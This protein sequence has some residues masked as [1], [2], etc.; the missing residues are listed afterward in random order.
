MAGKMCR[1]DLPP[2][3]PAVCPEIDPP[4]WAAMET[5][6][7]LFSRDVRPEHNAQEVLRFPPIAKCSVTLRRYPKILQGCQP[8]S[9]PARRLSRYPFLPFPR[10]LAAPPD[11]LRRPLTSTMQA[12]FSCRRT[13]SRCFKGA[14][15]F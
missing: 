8:L 10:L 12:T 6:A 13:V 2:P 11:S 4:A 9:T 3:W 14:C 1:L 15:T 7:P 5:Y